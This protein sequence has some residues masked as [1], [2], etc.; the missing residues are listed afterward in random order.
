MFFRKDRLKTEGSH[1]LI[2]FSPDVLYRNGIAPCMPIK[3]AWAHDVSIFS[4]YISTQTSITVYDVMNHFFVRIMI[5]AT[6]SVEVSH[7]PG[8]TSASAT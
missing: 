2:N 8:F 4:I 7:T 3:Q 6:R 1:H 5:C